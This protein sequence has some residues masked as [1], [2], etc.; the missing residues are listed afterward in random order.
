MV[1][2]ALPRV[3]CKPRDRAAMSGGCMS[4]SNQIILCGSAA[5]LIVNGL[6]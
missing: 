2:V 4:V 5:V 6:K 1:G 3:L